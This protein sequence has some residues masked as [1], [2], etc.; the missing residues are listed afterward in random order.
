MRFWNWTKPRRQSNRPSIRPFRPTLEVLE[1]RRAPAITNVTT[2]ADV[3]DP[4]D[5]VTSLREAIN[6][7]NSNEEKDTILLPAG[8]YAIQIAGND[9]DSTGGDFDLNTVDGSIEIRGPAGKNTSS[10]TPRAWTASST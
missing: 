6:I 1:G 5:G 7:A 8:T 4:S 2:T 10:L 3:V 9:N